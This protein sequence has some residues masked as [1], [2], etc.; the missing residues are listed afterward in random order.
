MINYASSL[1]LNTETFR[2]CMETGKYKQMVADELE[3]G[4]AKG[5]DRTPSFIVNGQLVYADTIISTIDA[6][7]KAKGVQ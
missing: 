1:G 5:V 4:K 6:A 3:N 2:S 7:L